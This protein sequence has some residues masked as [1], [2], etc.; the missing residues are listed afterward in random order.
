MRSPEFR[1]PQRIRPLSEAER[2]LIEELRAVTRTEVIRCALCD[3]D[4]PDS[5]E[6]AIATGWT[7]L[8]VDDGTHGNFLGLCPD[9]ATS[10][11]AF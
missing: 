1:D 4:G 3:A 9:C 10:N 6:A 8:Q 7:Q 11:E 2:K 5:L